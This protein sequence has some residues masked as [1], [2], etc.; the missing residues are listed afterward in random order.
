MINGFVFNRKGKF[1]LY[2]LYDEKQYNM[3]Q[4][5]WYEKNLAAN[6]VALI[7]FNHAYGDMY[8]TIPIVAVEV[9]SENDKFIK[10]ENVKIDNLIDVVYTAAK[11]YTTQKKQSIK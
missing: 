9:A 2:S 4:H 11:I 6:F 3:I 10:V 5:K 1:V 7:E 8:K